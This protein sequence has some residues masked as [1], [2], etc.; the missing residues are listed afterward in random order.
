MSSPIDPQKAWQRW[1]AQNPNIPATLESRVLF[2]NGYLEAW[3]DL[4][5][6]LRKLAETVGAES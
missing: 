5:A 4:Q 1:T 6:D 2:V 3:H